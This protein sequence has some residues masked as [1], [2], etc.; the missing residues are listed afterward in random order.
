MNNDQNSGK[1]HK[2]DISSY[3]CLSR[4]ELII[5]MGTSA[6]TEDCLFSDVPTKSEI[7]AAAGAWFEKH[8][9]EIKTTICEN[10]HKLRNRRNETIYSTIDLLIAIHGGLPIVFASIYLIDYGIERFCETQRSKFLQDLVNNDKK[11]N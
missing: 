1:N 9:D 5:R 6:L 4:E 8:Y 10:K 2:F 11:I 3:L 7:I